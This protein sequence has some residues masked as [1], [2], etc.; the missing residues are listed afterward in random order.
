MPLL[1]FSSLMKTISETNSFSLSHILHRVFKVQTVPHFKVY[2]QSKDDS[3]LVASALYVL[4]KSYLMSPQ[5]VIWE[6]R[7]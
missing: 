3:L 4:E 2:N 1:S 5:M 7:T 6:V